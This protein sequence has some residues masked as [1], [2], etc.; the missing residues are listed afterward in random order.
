MA[1]KKNT[2]GGFEEKLNRIRELADKL[3]HEELGLD[4]SMAL[5]TEADALVKECREFLETAELRI[6]KLIAS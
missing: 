4:E 3:Q 5:F 6:E 1:R 2:P